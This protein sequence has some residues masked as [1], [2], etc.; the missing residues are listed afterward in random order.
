MPGIPWQLILNPNLLSAAGELVSKAR[1]RPAE[2]HTAND[3]NTLRDRV[4]ELAKDEETQAETRRKA[5]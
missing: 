2:I 3:L 5:D 4:A 1:R